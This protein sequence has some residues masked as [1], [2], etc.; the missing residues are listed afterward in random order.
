MNQCRSFEENRMLRDELIFIG[1]QFLVQI[2]FALVIYAH[3]KNH[4]LPKSKGGCMT[5]LT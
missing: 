3:W 2:H 4:S 5:E 1:V